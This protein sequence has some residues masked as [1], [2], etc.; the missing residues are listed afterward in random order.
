MK[1]IYSLI[2]IF[3]CFTTSFANEAKL[4]LNCHPDAI[5]LINGCRQNLTGP[6]RIYTS[7]NEGTIQ[8]QVYQEGSLIG[9][10][11]IKITMDKMAVWSIFN[12]QGESTNLLDYELVKQAITASVASDEA[13]PDFHPFKTNIS[14]PDIIRKKVQNTALITCNNPEYPQSTQTTYQLYPGIQNTPIRNTQYIYEYTP[15]FQYSQPYY[16]SYGGSGGACAGGG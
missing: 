1:F 8:V 6:A 15:Q 7:P 12:Y 14:K 13:V 9:S 5:V 3:L 10:G 11:P 16:Q 4:K 2:V